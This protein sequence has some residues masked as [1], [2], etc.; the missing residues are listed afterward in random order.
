MQQASQ[1]LNE[2][3]LPRAVLRRSAAIQARLDAQKAES[4]APVADPNAPP[5]PPSAE[6]APPVAT[7]PPAP[8]QDPRENDPAYW[9]QRF[10]VTAGVLR[11]ERDER[12][13]EAAD[14]NRRIAELEDQI[15]NLQATAPS[16]SAAVDATTILTQEQIET[17]G[18]EE[19]QAVVDAALK[20]ARETAQKAIEAEVKP[21][22]DA[23]ARDA[24]DAQR[25]RDNA[26]LEKLYELAPDLDDKDENWLAWLAQEDEATGLQRQAILTQHVA[27]RD[28][29]NAFIEKLYELAPDLDDKDENWLAWLAQEDEATG[30]QR[31]VILTQHVAKRDPIKAAKMHAQ[32]KASTAAPAPPAPPVSPSGSGAAPAGLDPRQPTMLKAP[33]QAEIKDFYKRASLGRVTDAQRVEFEARL[34]LRAGR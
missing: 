13:A 7:T 30:L 23:R 31:Q 2:T 12:A 19:A 8:A 17:L 16:A 27:K 33:T 26:F 14:F 6:A 32:W 18:T 4:E 22:R 11:A 9:K 3:R 5:A 21:L 25:A 20:V 1:A 10:N 28:R 24:A 15:R 29:D 34:K